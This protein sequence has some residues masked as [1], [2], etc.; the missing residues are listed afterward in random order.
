VH[1]LLGIA[2][3]AALALLAGPP[4]SGGDDKARPAAAGKAA[5]KRFALRMEAVPWKKVF[6]WLADQTGLPVVAEQVPTGTFTF[7]PPASAGKAPRT[8]TIPE[9]LDVLND[10]LLASKHLLVRRANSFQLVA[11]DERLDPALVPL[12]A[13]DELRQRGKTEIVSTLLPLGAVEAKEALAAVKSLLGPFGEARPV[14]NR[15][16]LRDAAGNLLKV[17]RVLQEAET[18]GAGGT[19]SFAYTCKHV[20]AG[21]ARRIIEELLGGGRPGAK[22]GAGLT[23]V[24]DENTNTLHLR[25]P[26]ERVSQ[27][28]EALAR[29][30][31]P[32]KGGRPAIAE[33]VLKSYAVPS[34]QA[35]AVAKTLQALYAGSQRVRVTAVGANRILVYAS[36]EDQVEIGRQIVGAMPSLTVEAIPLTV[37]EAPRTVELLRALFAG[38]RGGRGGRGPTLEADKDENA[39]IIRGSKEQVEEVKT[40]LRALGERGLPGNIRVITVEHGQTARLAEELQKVLEKMRPNPVRVIAP[41]GQGEPGRKPPAADKVGPGAKKEA[42]KGAPPLTLTAVGN[43]LIAACD[44]QQVLALVRQLAG[45]YCIPPQ[46]GDV[47]VVRLQ[48][49][50]AAEVAKVLDEL[51]NGPAVPAAGGPRAERVRVVAEPAS[52][53]LLIKATPLDMLAIRGLVGK[54]LDV[55]SDRAEPGPRTYVLPPLR[56]AGAADLAKV[57]RELYQ[58]GGKPTFAV[59]LEARTNTLILRASPAVYEDVKKLVERLDVKTD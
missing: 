51:F 46:K 39:V 25:G 38:G 24:I 16:L 8:Y 43:K 17:V 35:E 28:K 10:A 41:L 1:V 12:V 50:G 5:E 56:H 14:G 15:L 36:P 34:G 45:L 13:P 18:D 7:L 22:G 54:T 48:H 49:A 58:G 3:C 52:N 23:A 31:V 20:K 21:E 32:G 19:V 29:I 33:P 27:A 26:A 53:S 37:L 47:Q 44:D 42:G 59:A 4:A 11:A 6:A 2:V 55:A 57:L 40:A 30:D 9:V